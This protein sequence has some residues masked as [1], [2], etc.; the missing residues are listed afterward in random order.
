MEMRFDR[1][2]FPE[3]DRTVTCAVD[4]VEVLRAE[5]EASGRNGVEQI[6]DQE[7]DL[8]GDSGYVEGYL[9]SWI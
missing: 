3:L 4:A 2:A 1:F 5:A 6:K 7:L 8:W 9:E